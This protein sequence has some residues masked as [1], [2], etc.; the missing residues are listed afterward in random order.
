[1]QAAAAHLPPELGLRVNSGQ[2]LSDPDRATLLAAARSALAA[3]PAPAGAQ[4]DTPPTAP[5]AA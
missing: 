3:H 1:V 2:P 5:G 4:P